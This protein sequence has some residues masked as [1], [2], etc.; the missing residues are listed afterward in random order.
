M[1]ETV[2]I[3]GHGTWELHDEDGLLVARGAFTNLVT[4]VGDTMYAERGAGIANLNTPTGMRL[5]TGLT[6]PSKAGAGAAIGSYVT[7]SARAF[8]NGYPIASTAGSALRITYRV[9]WPAGVATA[10]AIA[11]AV[12]TNENPLTDTAGTEA[13]TIARVLLRPGIDKAGGQ[14]FTLTL[15]HDQQG[16]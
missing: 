4:T 6:E 7:G 16:S 9:T 8:D 3:A 12:I 10:T 2:R 15:N 5:G 11:E 13:N 14:P 1:S